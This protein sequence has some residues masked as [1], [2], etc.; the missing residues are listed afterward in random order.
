M[1]KFVVATRGD[2]SVSRR[3]SKRVEDRLTIINHGLSAHQDLTW[4]MLADSLNGIRVFF[5]RLQRWLETEI[6][7]LDDIARIVGNGTI[8]V[9]QRGVTHG[10]PKSNLGDLCQDFTRHIVDFICLAPIE[11]TSKITRVSPHFKIN[12]F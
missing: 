1:V 10:V 5:R 12:D 3:S 4:L 2:G 11:K 9:V 8:K 7:I 6:T